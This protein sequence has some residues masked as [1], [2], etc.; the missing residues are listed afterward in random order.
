MPV[1]PTVAVIIL[2]WRRPQNIGRIV[3]AAADALPEACIF[4]LDQAEAPNSLEG[5][6]D[7]PWHLMWRRTRQNGGSAARIELAAALPF[8]HYLCIDDDLFLTVAQIK[9]LMFMLAKEPGRAHGVWGQV[10]MSNAEGKYQL[11]DGIVGRNTEVSFLNQVYA[12]AKVQAQEAM[13]LASLAGF[14]SWD[15]V[16]FCDD[17]LLSCSG[18]AC[19]RL[20]DFGQL[21]HCPTSNEPGIAEWKREGFHDRRLELAGEM[22]RLGRLH[23]D[24]KSTLLT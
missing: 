21:E 19:P 10:V 4:V 5:R 15:D 11:F 8:D 13:V 3:R 1:S 12:F 9:A 18:E 20:H 14:K 17:I 23:V 2:N 7:V 6:H 24:A 22:L 16:R